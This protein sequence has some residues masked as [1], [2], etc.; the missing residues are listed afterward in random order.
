MLEYGGVQITWL[1]HDGFK[2]KKSAVVY[3]D[4]FHIYWKRVV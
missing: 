2:L 4:P 3:V 1:G